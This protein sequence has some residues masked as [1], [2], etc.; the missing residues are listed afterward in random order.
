MGNGVISVT[1]DK[2]RTILDVQR[3]WEKLPI[4]FLFRKKTAD[5]LMW[6]TLWIYSIIYSFIPFR[7]GKKTAL[8]IAECGQKRVI[9]LSFLQIVD[10]I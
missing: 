7:S 4:S 5:I 1:K 6:I 3:G 8:K 2:Q 9:H 10:K